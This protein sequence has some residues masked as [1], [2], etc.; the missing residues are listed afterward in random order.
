MVCSK[1]KRAALWH[2]YNFGII[3]A[4]DHGCKDVKEFQHERLA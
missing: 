1:D 2:F 4:A 3:D